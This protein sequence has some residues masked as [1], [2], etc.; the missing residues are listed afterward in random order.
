VSSK[1]V[2]ETVQI[3]TIPA[4]RRN[5]S[6]FGISNAAQPANAATLAP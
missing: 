4:A 5:I 1:P 3:A 6:M 2:W